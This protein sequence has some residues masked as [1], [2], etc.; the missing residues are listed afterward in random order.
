VPEQHA[1][2]LIVGGSIGG[3]AAALAA[4][5]MG[6]RVI[7]TEETRW[8]GGQL[9]SQAVPPDEHPWIEQFGCTRRYRQFR[10]GVRQYYRDH[11][12]LTPAARADPYFN[13]GAGYVSRLCHEPRVGLAVLEGMLAYARSAGLLDVRLGRKPN[14]ADVAGDRV[15][16]VTL[17]RLDGSPDETITANYI[18][19]ATEL[20]ELL[21]L[22]GVEYVSGAESQSETG[23]PHALSGPADPGDVQSFTWCFAMG[24]DPI[25]EHLIDKPA[26]YERWRAYWP[27]LTPPWPAKLLS[28]NQVNPIT[29]QPFPRVLF[30]HES[31][32]PHDALWLY[33]RL[34]C[35][36]HYVGQAV[37]LSGGNPAGRNEQANSL[38]YMHEVTLVNWP[39]NDYWE[40][41]IIDVPEDEARRYLEES[42]QLSL[43]L[44]YWLQTEAPRPDG[45]AGYP[46]LY[47]RPDITG[48]EDGLALYPYIRESR[49]IKAVFTVLEQHVG[50]D[51][52]QGREAVHFGDSVGVGSYRID[53][54]PST[55][56]VN[57][58]DIS[59][60][61]FQIP[62]GALLPV[63]VENLLPAC[64][65]IGTTHITNG[66]YRLHPVEWNIG[67]AAGTLAAY[68][69][70]HEATP[71]QVRADA[72]LL[73]GF[74]KLLVQQGFELEW[75][76]TRPL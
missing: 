2:I 75:P 60:L 48:T 55:G 7:L 5:A 9:T 3:C 72:G 61:P 15:R 56:K 71:Q 25:G 8:I 1:D 69:L 27:Q 23:E 76:K 74:Q 32:N 53:L 54:H 43:S 26:Q 57:Y 24:Y 12:P 14:A 58:I 18:L 11:Y 19:D 38:P 33:R 64:K 49:R 40:G 51:A 70:A 29:L 10:D 35:R 31:P 66:C 17:R 34:I 28:M 4:T 22:A 36:D 37:S 62:L 65:N 67:E 30:P 21:P 52:R 6:Y 44:L 42:R 39:M 16:A 41:N 59:S 50:T 68:C 13:P 73:E 63:R 46:G 47:L 45:G 20:G